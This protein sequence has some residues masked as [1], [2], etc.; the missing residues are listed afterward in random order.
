VDQDVKSRIETELRRMKRYRLAPTPA[1]A[2]Y[3]L[4]AE[5]EYKAGV[6]AVQRGAG[7]QDAA[8]GRV[9]RGLDAPALY[10]EIGVDAPPN[11]LTSLI[12]LVVPAARMGDDTRFDTLMSMSLW[13]GGFRSASPWS[14]PSTPVSGA[15][16]MGAPEDV[17][18]QLHERP[19]VDTGPLVRSGDTWYDS[20]RFRERREREVILSSRLHNGACLAAQPGQAG[21][22]SAE[23]DPMSF[24]ADGRG[25]LP[26][27]LDTRLAA[28][29]APVVVPVA[30]NGADGENIAGLGP[31][32]FSVFENEVPHRV[33]YVRGRS[34][35]LT[36]A[37]VIDTSRSMRT[38]VTDLKAAASV[39]LEALG[40]ADR[41]LVV[42]FDSRTWLICDVTG[43]KDALRAAVVRP[44]PPGGSLSRL[45]DAIDVVL[46]ERL[47]K[48]AGRKAMVLLTDG[49]D[50]DSVQATA[51]SVMTRL[52][53]SGVPVY[54]VQFNSTPVAPQR[55]PFM[56]T[57]LA[58]PEGYFDARV[59]FERATKY[60]AQLALTTGGR[61]E[62]ASTADRLRRMADD[63]RN[64]YVLYYFPASPLEQ[65]EFRRI[66]VETGRSGAIVRAR[67]GC[68]APGGGG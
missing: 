34:D 19:G 57:L 17:V 39:F 37:L 65:G 30:V 16:V 25:A 50:V 8:R 42:T 46:A 23:H 52:E 11:L 24:A 45:Y 54:A 10:G 27:S 20:A 36:V 29:P 55:E 44:K 58:V 2:D 66:R 33:S 59:S 48:T 6:V 60:L 67:L 41:A 31:S 43:D 7:G 1:E 21:A 47:E 4:F 38:Y 64:Q 26:T 14:G 12:A 15:S 51:S 28:A 68:R 13:S 22:M 40:P 5:A 32:D 3:V 35:P 18:A 61:A 49:M 9:E 62:Q 53:A 56:G 63:M